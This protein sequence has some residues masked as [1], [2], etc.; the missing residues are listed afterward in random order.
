MIS[1]VMCGPLAVRR[2]SGQSSMEVKIQ[3]KNPEDA[4]TV[5]VRGGSW[6]TAVPSTCVLADR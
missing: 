5:C 3:C 4:R 1:G 6:P 2:L